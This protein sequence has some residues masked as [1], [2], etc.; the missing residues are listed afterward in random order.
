MSKS[1]IN[2]KHKE[3]ETEL[4]INEEEKVVTDTEEEDTANKSSEKTPDEA[5]DQNTG[6]ALAHELEELKDTHLR[7]R[8][9]YDNF[10]KR[11]LREKADLIKYAGEK[12]VVDFL[13]VVDDFDR[14][15]NNIPET[16]ENKVLRDGV[17]LIRNKMI[18]KLKAQGVQEMEV[19]GMDF[20]A[21]NHEAVAM[22][23]ADQ[24]KNK[25]KIID[26]IQKG[27]MLNDKVI[28]HPKVVVGQ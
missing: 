10:R 19:I 6:E 15:L 20:N 23:P 4:P 25:G 28:R 12:A 8:A 2:N 16:E 11:T 14:A 3:E 1:D 26:C 13:E 5:E 9:E 22:V 17:E 24:D 18:A 27:Y 21:E 7:L